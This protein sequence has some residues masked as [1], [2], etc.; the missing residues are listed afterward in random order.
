M[1][2]LDQDKQVKLQ[3]WT[4][5]HQRYWIIS[6]GDNE[7]NASQ[8]K[9]RTQTN[10][11]QPK[12]TIPAWQ[13]EIL[14]QGSAKLNKERQSSVSRFKVVTGEAS[15][16]GSTGRGTQQI[17]HMQHPAKEGAAVHD[18]DQRGGID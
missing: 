4:R 9:P 15:Q 17:Q 13:E 5:S 3:S 10:N 11:G 8:G 16:G 2:E 18:T 6:V 7:N 14:K 12:A 1:G